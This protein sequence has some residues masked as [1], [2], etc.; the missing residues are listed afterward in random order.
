MEDIKLDTIEWSALEYKHEEKSVDFLWTIGM[1]AVVIFVIAILMD[2]YLFAIFI[3]IA[4]AALILMSIRHPKE[5]NF[6]IDTFGLTLGKEKY[7]WKKVKGFDI[8]TS[9]NGSTL[10]VQTDKYFLPIYTIP[11]PAEKIDI[12]KDNLIKV[13]PRIELNESRSIKFME[14]IGF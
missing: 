1:V 9:E 6:S 4:A 8:K 3:V 2:N 7:L 10:L 12:I 14:K 13:I 11:L 5:I